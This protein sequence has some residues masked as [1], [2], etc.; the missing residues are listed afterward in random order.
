M[1]ASGMQR[2]NGK[3]IYKSM[4]KSLLLKRIEMMQH[5]G[6]RNELKMLYTAITRTRLRLI[7]FDESLEKRKSFERIVKHFDIFENLTEENFDK[8]VKILK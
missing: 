7:I 3:I 5:E 4:R 8:L 2:K 1:V 6:L